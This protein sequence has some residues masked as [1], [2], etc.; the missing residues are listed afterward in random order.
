MQKIVVKYIPEPMLA[1]GASFILWE[2]D[3]LLHLQKLIMSGKVAPVAKKG[4]LGEFLAS[5]FLLRA[6]DREVIRQCVELNI[7]VNTTCFQS[8]CYPIKVKHF[9]R[10]LFVD[11]S[12][13]LGDLG[14]GLVNFNCYQKIDSPITHNIIADAFRKC[15]ALFPREN[16]T[17][18]DIFIPV[19]L[20]L[21]SK[22]STRKDLNWNRFETLASN[23]RL[24]SCIAIQVK[25]WSSTIAE[26]KAV[27]L[28]ETR[29]IMFAVILSWRIR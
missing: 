15:Y 22:C 8:F 5:V 6:K 25:N 10:M 27:E 23:S 12:M 3:H 24:F 28:N 2:E 1:D 29:R 14:E 21:A 17:A 18:F 16:E 13:D 11:V 19:L 20:P 7:P 9:L 26:N 4:D